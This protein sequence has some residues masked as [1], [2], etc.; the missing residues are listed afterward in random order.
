MVVV[1]GVP[2]GICSYFS[3]GKVRD[4]LYVYNFLKIYT[5]I[6]EMLS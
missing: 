4:L 3:F 1:F 2:K 6:L 5:Q